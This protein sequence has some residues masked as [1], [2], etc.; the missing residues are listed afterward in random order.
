M[1]GFAPLNPACYATVKTGSGES[2][3]SELVQNND[4]D[5]DGLSDEEEGR[6]DSDMTRADTDGD[7]LND[8]DEYLHGTSPVLKDTDGDRFS[9]AVEVE[10]GP[11]PWIPNRSREQI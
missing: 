8:G 6:F 7:G 5:H 2:F 9:D 10:K 1:L 4:R 11:I 3:L